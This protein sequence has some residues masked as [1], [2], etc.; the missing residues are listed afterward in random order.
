MQLHTNE[1]QP[2]SQ[3]HTCREC[4][5][6]VPAIAN[7]CPLCGLAERQG[8][9]D[10]FEGPELPPDTEWAERRY[11]PPPPPPPALRYEPFT[12]EKAKMAQKKGAGLRRWRNR[13]RDDFIRTKTRVGWTQQRIADWLHV[14]QSTVSRV[15]SSPYRFVR[16]AFTT[17]IAGERVSDATCSLRQ[18]GH[19]G[20]KGTDGRLPCSAGGRLE[21]H[22]RANAAH[23]RRRIA[24]LRMLGDTNQ[25]RLNY[26]YQTRC[27]YLRRREMRTTCPPLLHP[28]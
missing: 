5:Y 21:V 3:Q 23:T 24:I 22:P 18:G 19:Y 13:D 27:C 8:P 1:N 9:V 12:S 15:L 11:A 7:F 25:R 28:K 10:R 20:L 26:D 4:G 2:N 16:Y 14:V 6:D 17:L